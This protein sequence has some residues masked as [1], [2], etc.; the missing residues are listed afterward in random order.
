M[1]VHYRDR[2]RASSRTATIRWRDGVDAV[3]RLPGSRRYLSSH[4]VLTD[5]QTRIGPWLRRLDEIRTTGAVDVTADD[6]RVPYRDMDMDTA[7]GDIAEHLVSVGG[8]P[9]DDLTAAEVDDDLAMPAEVIR[10][11]REWLEACQPREATA[12]KSDG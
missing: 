7:L 6:L 9:A 3:L 1:T 10:V 4:G 2:L 12:G 8:L 11:W 5:L